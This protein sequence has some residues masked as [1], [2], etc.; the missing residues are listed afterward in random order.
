MWLFWVK[1]TCGVLTLCHHHGEKAELDVSYA[2]MRVIP[3]S[4]D[5][6]LCGSKDFIDFNCLFG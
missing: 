6:L 5:Q 3:G 2:A 1:A 4:L